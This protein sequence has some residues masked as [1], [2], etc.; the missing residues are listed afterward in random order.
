M[1]K[2]YSLI[3]SIVYSIVLAALSL[4]K[5]NAVTQE[6]PSNSD[7]IFHALAYLIFT[8]VW[9]FA[10]FYG[11]TQTKVK[12]ICYAFVSSLAFGIIIEFLQGWIT[13]NRQS[14]VNDVIANI[15]GTII[16]VIIIS[17]LK[18]GVLKNN[19]ALLF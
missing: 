10:F 2:K 14:D 8:I 19:N 9:F 5:I 4:I 16:A 15:I 18:K 17:S 7:K 12:A 11:R 13:Q 3:I 1:L 6:F